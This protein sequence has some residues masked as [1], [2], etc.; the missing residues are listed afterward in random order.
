[1]EKE[2]K[3]I[4]ALHK[5]PRENIEVAVKWEEWA[6]RTT[7]KVFQADD[8]IFSLSVLNQLLFGW[9]Q[10]YPTAQ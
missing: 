7:R 10:I 1:M 9:H 2:P 5:H 8:V 3:S 6:F 4:P